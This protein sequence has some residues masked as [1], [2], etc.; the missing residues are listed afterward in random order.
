MIQQ[1][2]TVREDLQDKYGPDI[3]TDYIIDFIE[4]NK[5][6]QFFVY[7]PMIL[8]HAPFVRTPDSRDRGGVR[9]Q[10]DK[11][12]FPDM[13]AYT[14]KIVGRIIKALEKLG[15]RE[16]TLLLFTGD[17]GSPRGISSKMGQ[18]SIMGGKGHTTE[19]GTHVPF[20]AN[21]KGAIPG[22]QICE[23]LVDFTDF[24]PTLLEISGA[25]PPVGKVLDGRKARRIFF[26]PY[27]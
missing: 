7:F 19:A 17:N 27:L 15:L 20:I 21:W 11:A 13:V 16:N 18:M 6:K 5:S 8:T 24:L 1:N 25:E 22:G 14:D 9:T 4:R 3:C 2:G 10:R 26:I 12:F 23:D